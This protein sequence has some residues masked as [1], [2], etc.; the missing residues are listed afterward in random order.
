MASEGFGFI[1]N[2]ELVDAMKLVMIIRYFMK[3]PFSIMD[4][5]FS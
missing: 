2:S 4:Y 1:P 5:F 3:S